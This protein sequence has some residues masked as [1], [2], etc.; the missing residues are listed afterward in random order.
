MAAA[1]LFPGPGTTPPIGGQQGLIDSGRAGRR[2]ITPRCGA[3]ACRPFASATRPLA[4]EG[5]V[6]KVP[7]SVWWAPGRPAVVI[8]PSDIDTA[9][10]G[11]VHAALTRSLESRATVII[12]DMTGTG[13]CGS[14]GARALAQTRARAAAAGT[15][16]R[17]AAATYQVRRMLQITGAACAQDIYPDL[18]SAA[19]GPTA[20]G[21][22]TGRTAGRHRLRVIPGG[23]A[24]PTATSLPGRQRRMT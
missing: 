23:A 22:D 1:F 18:A 20:R 9:N 14:A 5:T 24:G 17:V 16:L 4:R 15:Q 10:S 3:P 2:P 13:F 11:K 8:L 21:K 7:Y 12:A 19:A 6:P